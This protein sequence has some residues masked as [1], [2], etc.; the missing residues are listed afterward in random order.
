MKDNKVYVDLIISACKKISEYIEGV[1]EA[2]FLNR[3]IVQSAVIMQLQVI[4]EEAK[5]LDE[6][7][8]NAVDVPWK[9]I[10][11]LRNIIAHEYFL[12]EVATIWKIASEN[13]PTLEKKLHAFLKIQGTE[14]VPPFD[15]TSPLMD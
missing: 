12:L 2:A 9:M 11:G 5:K 6:N 10:I 7:T 15:N 8:K 13:I 1:D 14:Y 3:S 4:G